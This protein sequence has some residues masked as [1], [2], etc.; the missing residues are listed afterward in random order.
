MNIGKRQEAHRV[1]WEARKSLDRQLRVGREFRA[2]RETCWLWEGEREKT[3]ASWL[4]GNNEAA[5]TSI[6][7]CWGSCQDPGSLGLRGARRGAQAGNFGQSW[8]STWVQMPYQGAKPNQHRPKD[9]PMDGSPPFF[10]QSTTSGIRES[11]CTHKVRAHSYRVSLVTAKHV[12]APRRPA[13]HGRQRLSVGER[14]AWVSW[15]KNILVTT[16]SEETG[17]AQ[18]AASWFQSS[19]TFSRKNPSDCRIVLIR[20]CDQTLGVISLDLKG[21]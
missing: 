4:Q 9:H 12:C 18:G 10:S 16:H 6:P 7:H 20:K 13:G 3:L 21:M 5:E 2:G 1:S 15:T 17:E 11:L 19:D 8:P 14:T